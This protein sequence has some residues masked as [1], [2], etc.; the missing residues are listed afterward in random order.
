[1]HDVAPPHQNEVNDL[2]GSVALVTGAGRA[3][4]MGRATALALA[5]AGADIVVTDIGRP[6]ADLEIHGIGLGDSPAELEETAALVRALGRKALALPL[7][8][9]DPVQARAVVQEATAALGVI[10]VLVNNAGTAAGSGPLLEVEPAQW[11]LSWSVNVF[12]AVNLIQA[13]APGMVEAGHGT[14]VN[15][16]STLGL[17]ALPDYGS[18]VVSKHGV[19]GLTRLLAQELGPS[20]IRTNAVAPGFIVTDMGDAERNAIAGKLGVD[21]DVAAGAIAQEIPLGRI[22]TPGDVA[23]VTT[24]LASPASGFVNGAVIPVSGGQIAGFV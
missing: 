13:V 8:V 18:Y 20:G 15:V 10:D 9:T 16:A 3:R 14:I 17:A 22:G 5:A 11:Q 12:G 4:G 6:R 24:W 1:M 7:D 21:P 2:H 19:V 23:R